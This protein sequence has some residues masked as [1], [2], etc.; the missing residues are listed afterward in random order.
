MEIVK[1]YL[2]TAD[3][4]MN[5]SC[6]IYETSNRKGRVSYKKIV[7]IEDLELFLKRVKIKFAR[8]WHLFLQSKK[9]REYPNTELRKLTSRE[10][11]K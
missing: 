3:Y 1:L 6:G 7:G 4:T 5:K 10:S 11:L 2:K 9:Y 8:K